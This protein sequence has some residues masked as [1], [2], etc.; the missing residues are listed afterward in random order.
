MKFRHISAITLLTCYIFSYS[1]NTLANIDIDELEIDSSPIVIIEE[2]ELD[3]IMQDYLSGKGKKT[4]P[5]TKTNGDEYFLATG[6]GIIQAPRTSSSYIASRSAAFD[7]ALL[8]AKANLLEF[9]A[10][11]ISQSTQLAMMEDYSDGEPVEVPT[12]KVEADIWGKGQLLLNAKVDA[13]L[14]N[15]GV[16]LD[17]EEAER[18]I[19]KIIESAEF[20]KSVRSVSQSLL[21]GVQTYKVFEASPE[22]DKG[23]VGVIIVHSNKLS[24]M[25]ASI[26]TGKV[27]KQGKRNKPLIEQFPDNLLLTTLGVRQVRDESGNYLL[28]SFGQAGAR[29]TTAQGKKAAR[30]KAK[31]QAQSYLRAFAGE[32]A[33]RAEEAMFAESAQTLEGN[34]ELYSNEETS[35]R[36]FESKSEA[37]NMTG[38]STLKRWQLQHPLTGQT[39]YGVIQV[40]SPEGM[41]RAQQV[42][43]SMK[44]SS[45]LTYNKEVKSGTTNTQQGSYHGEGADTDDDDF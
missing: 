35:K 32:N 40:W 13:M 1:S 19:P 29:S 23:E 43:K 14:K 20:Q 2:A 37:L 39:V 16:E 7:K 24:E 18:V 21:T 15:E 10:V 34:E 11:E 41:V 25:A 22:G 9:I 17:S 45:V 30:S 31:L 8:E 38:I 4:G 44:S 12:P 5:G 33:S 3:D 28:V 26:V 27:P 6:T 42:E 36:A